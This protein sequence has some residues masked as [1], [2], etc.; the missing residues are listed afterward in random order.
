MY[1]HAHM[2]KDVAE[3]TIIEWKI[4]HVMAIIDA[5]VSVIVQG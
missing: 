1:H 3:V 2:S 5:P 4:N